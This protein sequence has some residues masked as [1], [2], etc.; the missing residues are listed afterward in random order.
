PVTVLQLKGTVWKPIELV[1]QYTVLNVPP[2]VSTTSATIRIVSHIDESLSVW[3][4]ECNSRLFNIVL[5]T[6]QPGKEFQVAIASISDLPQ[7]NIQ[8]KVTLKTS[9]P[10]SPTLEMPFWVNV[11][12][13]LTVTPQRIQLPQAPLKAKAPNAITIS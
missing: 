5:T 11:Q 6:N 2:D 1:P 8:G 10:K 12:P 3:A 13:F 9:S 4:P 7:G